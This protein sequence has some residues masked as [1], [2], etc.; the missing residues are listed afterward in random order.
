MR[1]DQISAMMGR[2][3]A[4]DEL[5]SE[6]LALWESEPHL[7]PVDRALH[8]FTWFYLQE[9]IL[10]KADRASMMSSLESRAVF[11]DNDLVAFCERLP[12]GFKYRRGQRKYLL[13][14]ALRGYLPDTI[15][16]RPKKGFGIPLAKWLRDLPA[17][18]MAEIPGL[19]RTFIQSLWDEHR[20]GRADHRIALWS[21]LSLQA[22]LG[23]K[24]S[25]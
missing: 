16:D 14:K 13:R 23:E 24:V 4:A 12:N 19:D 10:L 11:L 20:K 2:T 25:F 5:Y 17:A 6:A 9:D 1:P 8:F 15:L 7:D 21:C 3:F 22:A 18:R